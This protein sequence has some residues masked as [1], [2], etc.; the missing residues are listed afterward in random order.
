MVDSDTLII[1]KHRASTWL[2]LLTKPAWSFFSREAKYLR[3]L[4]ASTRCTCVAADQW[5]SKYVGV[6]SKTTVPDS[7]P[8]SGKQL[9]VPD[10]SDFPIENPWIPLPVT[11][12]SL[13]RHPRVFLPGG[14]IGDRLHSPRSLCNSDPLQILNSW[15]DFDRN[16]ISRA[17]SQEANGSSRV[18][19]REKH[20]RWGGSGLQA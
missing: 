7:I 2:R 3:Q 5:G 14:I 4:R 13:W 11:A 20:Q 17:S 10:R 1:Y 19:T 8:G 18:A 16:A 6:M 15:D 12:Q 9:T